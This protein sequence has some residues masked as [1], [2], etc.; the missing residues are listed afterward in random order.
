MKKMNGVTL[1]QIQGGGWWADWGAGLL[2]G[3]AVASIIATGGGDVIVAVGACAIAL[4]S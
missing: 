3:A 1:E 2:C 4:D